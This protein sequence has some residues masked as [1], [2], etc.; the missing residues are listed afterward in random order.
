MD[1]ASTKPVTTPT[2]HTEH[3]HAL[4]EVSTSPSSVADKV[5]SSWRRCARQYGVNPGSND[6]P[7]ILTAEELHDVRQPLE[8]L[9]FSAREEMDRLYK[10]VREAGYTSLLCDRGGVAV[11]HRGENA[12][13]KEFRYWGTWLGGVWAEQIEGT[14]GI[15]TC[16]AEER[17][18]TVHRTEHFRSRHMNLSCSGAPIFDVDGTLIAV[19]DVSAVD[20]ELSEHAHALTGA[21]TVSSA[22]TISER[23]FR[24]CF[25]RQWIVAIALP[26]P[27][28]SG[29]LLA[30][31]DDQRL[32]G[33]DRLARATFLLDDRK[34]QQGAGLWTIFERNRELFRR[35]N[36]TDFA[37]RL[38]T[39]GGDESYAALVTAPEGTIN[40]RHD[41]AIAALHARPRLDLLPA[42]ARPASRRPIRAGISPSA[43]QRVREHVDAHLS[44]RMGLIE[45]AAVAG[46]SVYHFA[47]GFKRATGETPHDY[48]T[49]MRV[50]RARDMLVRSE[51]HLSEIAL[52]VGFYDQSHLARHFRQVLGT[53]PG[54]FRSMHR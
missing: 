31:D 15:G 21:L 38:I 36:G 33:A 17:P 32:I 37:V 5:L 50:E 52:A 14:N 45:M 7:R 48:L 39:A 19:L 3:V 2:Q 42:L 43:L 1:S 11:D 51:L 28:S 49:R 54:E 40:A 35:K 16:I 9:I 46:V 34:L 8:E 22:R 53:S 41:P 20:P 4:A 29:M 25:H 30:V 12:K 6:A 13:A 10:V 23:F 24:E 27:A 44:R 18:I 47:R 26:G